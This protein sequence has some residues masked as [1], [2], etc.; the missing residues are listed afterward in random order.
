MRRRVSMSTRSGALSARDTVA[1]D[2]PARRATSLALDL[3]P[4]W[5]LGPAIEGVAS[6]QYSITSLAIRVRLPRNQVAATIYVIE[7]SHRPPSRGQGSRRPPRSAAARGAER[8][9][10]VPQS[11]AGAMFWARL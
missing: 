1:V 8:S 6:V 5:G 10:K 7:Y 2:T 9:C 11:P 4:D 3:R